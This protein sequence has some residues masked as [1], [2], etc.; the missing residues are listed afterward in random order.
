MKSV[1][2]L[3]LHEISRVSSKHIVLLEPF[4]DCNKTFERKM[5]T[6]S[7]DYFSIKISELC[8]FG[9]KPL[10]VFK[11]FPQKITRGVALVYAEKIKLKG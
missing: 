11:D 1:Q 2:E 8:N 10:N 3:V 7:T 5:F 6:K 4:P 9:I